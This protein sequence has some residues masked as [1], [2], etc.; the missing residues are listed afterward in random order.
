AAAIFRWMAEGRKAVM[1]ELLTNVLYGLL[2]SVGIFA[3]IFVAHFSY[4]IPRKRNLDAEQKIA[5]MSRALTPSI[6]IEEIEYNLRPE[7]TSVCYLRFINKA[8]KTADDVRIQM[9]GC[10][11]PFAGQNLAYPAILAPDLE[12]T[13]SLNPSD[14]KDR[15]FLVVSIDLVARK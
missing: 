13:R 6:E 12:I 7:Q 9:T 15:N 11:V 1:Q 2:G 8:S 14:S 10:E 5:E 3:L 4:F